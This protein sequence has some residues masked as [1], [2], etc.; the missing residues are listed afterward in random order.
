MPSTFVPDEPTG[1]PEFIT[2]SRAHRQRVSD[3]IPPRLR[4]PSTIIDNLPLDVTEIPRSCGLLTT[5][6]I[7]ITDMDATAVRDAV[8]SRSVT[9]V[10]AV[11]AF[12]KRAAI[13]H[14]LVNC[15]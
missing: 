11:T 8:A 15:K 9:A 5:G 7:D 1:T 4:L 14:Q 2:N 10:Q 13:A 3:A 12:A 6:E